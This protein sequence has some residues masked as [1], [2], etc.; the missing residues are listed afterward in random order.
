LLIVKVRSN[1]VNRQQDRL[2]QLRWL[3]ELRPVTSGQIDVLDVVQGREF[4]NVL[5]TLDDP[6]A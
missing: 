4:R 2:R 3:S 5:M 1:L 6:L